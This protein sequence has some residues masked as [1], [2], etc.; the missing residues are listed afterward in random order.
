[1]NDLI[2]QIDGRIV[3]FDWSKLFDP[4]YLFATSPGPSQ[5]VGYVFLFALLTGVVGLLLF[6]FSKRIRQLEGSRRV[7]LKE[8]GK[9]QAFLSVLL[10]LLVFFRTQE[11]AFLSMRLLN[12]ITLTFMFVNLGFMIYRQT[13]VIPRKSEQTSTSGGYN[14]YLPRKRKK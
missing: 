13:G 1:M 8:F 2:S 6:L 7:L 3:N 5:Y 4:A 9:R 10:L 14:E 11:L 12:L